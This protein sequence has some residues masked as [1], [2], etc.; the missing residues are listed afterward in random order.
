LRRRYPDQ[1]PF[2][3]IEVPVQPADSAAAPVGVHAGA[4][5]G[6]TVP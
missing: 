4:G 6:A 5:L 3:V 1:P 2:R